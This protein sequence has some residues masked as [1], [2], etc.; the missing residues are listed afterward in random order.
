ME[1]PL[2]LDGARGRDSLV[3]PDVE[4]RGRGGLVAFK[5]LFHVNLKVEL[6]HDVIDGLLETGETLRW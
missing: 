4:G 3:D 5:V 1:C 2:A 6:N